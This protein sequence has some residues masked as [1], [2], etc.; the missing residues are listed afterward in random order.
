MPLPVFLFPSFT[1]VLECMAT[2]RL[3]WVRLR[4]R[5]W[6]SLAIALL[7]LSALIPP[8]C[9]SSAHD[10]LQELR[11]EVEALKAGQNEMQKTLQIVKDILLGKQ[12]PLEDVFV[13]TAGAPSLGKATAK[14]TIVEF[15]DFQCPFCGRYATQTMPQ[16]L[17]EY[18]K[19]GKVRYVFRNFP[20]EQVHP[21][22]EKAAEAS[23]CA[24]DQDKFWEAHDRFFKNQQ[25]LDAKQMQ[26]H[27]AALGLD[28]VKFQQCL[29]SGKYAS[30][31]KGDIAE[32]Q[33]YNVRGTPSFFFGT[34]VKDSKLKAAK[35]LSGALPYQNFKD[36][37]D[38][39]LNP[40][41]EQ[42]EK[43]RQ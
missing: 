39:L 43:P 41:N 19:T 12:P 26:A 33:R 32:G 29:D 17:D 42:A 13:S 25:L 27:A 22:A 38:G 2:P 5:I 14:I 10:D 21:S 34:E 28:T 30:F 16:L 9:A 8:A 11:K 4:I 40:P 24:G 3:K 18:V 20:L 36:V 31:V 37:I 1:R 23:A 35:F 6:D 7:I 15:S